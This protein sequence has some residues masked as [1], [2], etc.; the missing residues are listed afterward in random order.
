[1]EPTTNDGFV[2][3]SFDQVFTEITTQEEVFRQT[4]AP[5]VDEILRGYNCTVFACM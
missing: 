1:M 3:F 2:R 4:A 5:M